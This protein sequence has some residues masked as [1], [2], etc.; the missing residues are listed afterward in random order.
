[1]DRITLTITSDLFDDDDV[2]QQASVRANLTV[3]GLVE[4]IRRE[5]NLLDGEYTLSTKGSK[6]A[7]DA[8]KTMDQLD[9]K[10]GAELVFTRQRNRL[11]Q[12]IVA[13][14]GQFFQA[15]TG[16]AQAMLR[17]EGS[18]KVYALEWQPAII[19]RPDANNAASAEM[20]AVNLGDL[21]E[22]RT[23]SR[24]H[25][26]ISE[27]GGQ[28]YLEGLAQRNPTFLNDRELLPGEKRALMPGDEIR[29][30]KIML[31]F[32]LQQRG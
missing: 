5:F 32:D 29:V 21:P 16:R 25:A 12:Q 3:R 26:R 8:D 13:R 11:S 27:Y 31:T 4:E 2:D 15:I 24:Q 23:V 14:G 6:K 7:L 22:A 1:M 19:G 18:A 17:E 30:G 20:L 10:T 9:L 28:F